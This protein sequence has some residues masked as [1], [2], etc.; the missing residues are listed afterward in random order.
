MAILY[1]WRY[2]PRCAT[3]LAHAPGRVT[4][5][6]C[7]FVAY[8]NSAPT[9]TALVEDDQGRV[10]LARRGIEPRLGLWDGLGGYLEENEHPLAGLRRELREETGLEVEPV[11][12]VGVFLDWYDDAPDANATLNLYWTGRIVSGE[13]IPADDVADVEWFAPSRLPP[14]DEI[15]FPSLIEALAAWQNLP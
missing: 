11:R 10:L 15:A 3:E 7:G 14:P 9:V 6:V 4:C 12:F 2:C 1:R 5:A 13:L 8:A